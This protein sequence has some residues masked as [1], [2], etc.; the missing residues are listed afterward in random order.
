MRNCHL[1]FL[2]VDARECTLQVPLCAAQLFTGA[3]EGIQ[4]FTLDT[5]IPAEVFRTDVGNPITT[6]LPTVALS[7]V[8]LGVI[9]R[10]GGAKTCETDW[11]ELAGRCAR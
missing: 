11:F 1:L 6:N 7:P 5:S 9:S 4:W 10:S 8:W 3:S 2:T